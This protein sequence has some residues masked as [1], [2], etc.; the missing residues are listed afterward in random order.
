MSFGYRAFFRWEVLLFAHIAC[1]TCIRLHAVC[2][3]SKKRAY[4]LSSGAMNIEKLPWVKRF[5]F[6]NITLMNCVHR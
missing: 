5:V 4:C 6:F 1:N 2:N 3:L